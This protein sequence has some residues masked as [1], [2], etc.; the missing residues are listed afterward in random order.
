MGREDPAG[1]KTVD[2]A[3]AAAAPAVDHDRGRHLQA[4]ARAATGCKLWP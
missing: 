2:T 1:G 4:S 3:T